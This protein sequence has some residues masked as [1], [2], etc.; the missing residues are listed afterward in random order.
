MSYYVDHFVLM[1]SQDNINQDNP[2]VLDT[3]P[4]PGLV[5]KIKCDR[6]MF[7]IIIIII[8]IIFHL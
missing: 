6:R 5:I 4:S 8:I 1:S 3:L 2:F 7:I